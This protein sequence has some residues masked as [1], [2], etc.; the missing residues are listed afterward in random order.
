MKY[1][2]DVKSI[3]EL[4]KAYK[5]LVKRLHPDLNE[6][7]TTKQFQEM[8]NEFEQL[9]KELKNK[10]INCK[11]EYYEKET[12]IDEDFKPIIDR[13]VTLKNVN[14][15]IIGSWIWLTGET[16]QYKDLIKSLKFIW[17]KDKRA[18]SYH[19][20]DWYKKRSA[21]KLEEI[22]EL[23]GTQKIDNIEVELLGN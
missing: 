2:K 22:R 18:W 23:Y 21:M 14:I 6:I 4:K 10:H 7:D 12:A 17:S 15:E 1:F 11:G 19:K 3:E 16:L 20:E 8:G 9:Q 5:E 13:L